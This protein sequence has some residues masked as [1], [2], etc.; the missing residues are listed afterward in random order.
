MPSQ[1]KKPK[2]SGRTQTTSGKE[3]Y[4]NDDSVWPYCRPRPPRVDPGVVK[5]WTELA[6]GRGPRLDLLACQ[7]VEWSKRNSP[8]FTFAPAVPCKPSGNG[9]G[10]PIADPNPKPQEPV[11]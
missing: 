4:M 7:F 9:P 8:A 11:K 1:F 5:K 2:K 6:A 3:P 10:A